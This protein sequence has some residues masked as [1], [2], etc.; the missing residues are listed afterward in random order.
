FQVVGEPGKELVVLCIGGTGESVADEPAEEA[1]Q[2]SPPTAAA[3]PHQDALHAASAPQ[4]LSP[5]AAAW[6]QP[7]EPKSHHAHEPAAYSC[8]GQA[9]TAQADN[10]EG[11]PNAL[12]DEDLDGDFAIQLRGLPYRATVEDLKN[13]LGHHLANVA[14][15]NPVHLVLN[16]DGRPSGFARVVFVSQEAAKTARDDLH[17]RGMEDRYV[18]VFLYS[19]RPSKGRTRKL[20]DGQTANST[21]AEAAGVTKEQV[22]NECRA[23]MR[24]GAKRR[25]LLSMLGVTLSSG[26][27]AY[28]KQIDQGLKHFLAQYPSEFGVDGSKG[29]EYVVYAPQMAEDMFAQ[30]LG[31]RI[32]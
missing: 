30:V 27:R 29:C 13:F 20:E 21:L 4:Q 2:Q 10:A 11:G 23:E 7:Q 18:E 31:Q 25:M 12:F 1:P 17:L 22:V 5:H 28:L 3:A 8:H 14:D 26:A 15:D 6:F 32:T 9:E 24:P 19:E 16:R